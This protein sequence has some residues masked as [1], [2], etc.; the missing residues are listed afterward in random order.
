MT[1]ATCR[2]V[3]S[4]GVA[5]L[6][7]GCAESSRTFL[8]PV[9][10]SGQLS[11]KRATRFPNALKYSDAGMKPATGRSG[12]AMLIAEALL[13][14]DGTATL[15]VTSTGSDGVPMGR[16]SHVQIK[17]FDP[18]G[19]LQRTTNHQDISGSTAEFT[20]PTRIRGST[21]QVQASVGGVDP[22]R[23]GVVTVIETIKL[24]PD[25]AVTG[26]TH[27]PQVARHAQSMIYMDI[28]ELNGDVG[29]RTTCVLEIDGLA[30]DQAMSLWVDAGRRVG[31]AFVHR[32]AEL[33]THSITVRVTDIVPGDY[34]VTNNVRSSSVVVV[35]PRPPLPDNAFQWDGSVHG[36]SGREGYTLYEGW[37]QDVAVPVRNDF[38]FFTQRSGTASFGSSVGGIAAR[39]LAGPVTVSLRDW[40]D[41]TPV[42]DIRF[43]ESLDTRVHF[44][45]G[46]FSQDCAFIERT[47]DIT[48][49][50]GPATV[51]IAHVATCTQRQGGQALDTWFSY[52][53]QNAEIIYYAESWVR[54]VGPGYENTWSFA[55]N[56]AEVYGIL[57]FG[58]E[59]RFELVI[60]SGEER[61]VASGVIP[62]VAEDFEEVVPRQ[63]ATFEFG[64]YSEN[65]C[66]ESRV[67][68]RRYSGTGS[69][70]PATIP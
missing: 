2:R 62:V 39:A 59:Y 5:L 63:C 21:V 70:L 56:V 41:A 25:V 57:A 67:T 49:P 50:M 6:L 9:N 54:E 19:E 11:N 64:T 20:L 23:T 27:L 29:A 8:E 37:W 43:D 17:Q 55:G 38:R 1:V 60:S 69:G 32:F 46:D 3:A 35:D 14:R 18:E 40:V 10:A 58:S 24:R 52:F 33:G 61:L 42:Q 45:L 48:T 28:D 31:C 47:A 68:G 65:S 53:Q 30:V 51:T 36:N 22:Q 13:G 34:D 26:L 44:E 66:F 16:L 12:G 7:T 4:L 15:A